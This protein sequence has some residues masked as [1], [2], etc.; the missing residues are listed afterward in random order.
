MDKKFL[1][2]RNLLA[3]SRSN[4]RLCSRLSAASTREN[5]YRFLE[6][7]SG[8]TI[9]ALVLD[10]GSARPLHSTVD[11]ER[12][13]QRLVS[14]AQDEG[15]LVFLGLGGGFAPLA[16]LG[17][18]SQV[19]VIDY[20]CD[21]VAELLCSRDYAVLFGDPRFCFLVDPDPQ[22]V[23]ECITLRY[24][25]VLHGGIRAIPLIPRT[26]G[27]NS[28]S[29]ALDGIRRA[30][31]DS[32]RDYS[33]QAWFGMR[34]FS[35][36]VRN[37]PLA[38]KSW[39]SLPS[40]RRAA[41][42]AA[43]PS[44]ESQLPRIVRERE[45]VF[46]IASDT[47]LPVLLDAGIEPDGVLSIDCQHISYQHFFSLPEKTFLFADLASPPV[48]AVRSKRTVFLAGGHPLARYIQSVWRPFP[49]L[50]T[51]GANVAGAAFS[52]AESMGASEIVLYGADFSYP[53]GKT[54]ARGTYIYP[55]FEKKQ[56]RFCPLESGHSAFLYR[57]S[58]LSKRSLADGS[59]CYETESLKFYRSMLER[60]TFLSSGGSG[61]FRLVP[62]PPLSDRA[63]FRLLCPG[64]SR[65]SADEFLSVYRSRLRALSSFGEAEEESRNVVT[66]ILPAAAAFRRL[67]PSIAMN[68]LFE[69]TRDWC[70][71]ELD[72]VLNSGSRPCRT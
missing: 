39:Y 7:R 43:G 14:T 18:G 53:M 45:G 70:L 67:E 22:A 15:F 52:L 69:K 41:V 71:G 21:G 34:W 1:F 66:T 37:L 35:N 57:S 44:L 28:F 60:R 36:I 25:P 30:I 10:S 8:Q 27:D 63:P 16:A 11:P 61:C 51:S 46:L 23:E 62:R 72:R 9:P 24:K 19:L 58:S 33:V 17:K 48:V 29:G 6:S 42:T 55:F 31:E 4:P 56:S 12:E 32:S 65:G 3:L 64:N 49:S 38:E 26:E 68:D 50:D 5:T 13:A 2:D 20:G 59:W 40:I 47:S 54:Y